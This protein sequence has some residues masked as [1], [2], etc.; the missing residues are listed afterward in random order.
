VPYACNAPISP[1]PDI[2]RPPTNRPDATGARL[3]TRFSFV[4]RARAFLEPSIGEAST[5]HSRLYYE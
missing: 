4:S 3:P 2:F 1:S 5:V